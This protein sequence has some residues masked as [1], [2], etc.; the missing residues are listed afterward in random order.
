M[1][2]KWTTEKP[3]RAG[4]YWW[5]MGTRDAEIVEIEEIAGI[6]TVFQTGYDE[7]LAKSVKFWEGEWAGPLEEP[8]EQRAA[9]ADKDM[10]ITTCNL[11]L[12]ER[13]REIA[14][15]KALL[16]KQEEE[17]IVSLRSS[18]HSFDLQVRE[19]QADL[20]RVIGEAV[21]ATEM[22]QLER[23]SGWADTYD[24]EMSDE[25]VLG[26]L[27]GDSVYQRANAFL[28]GPLVTCWRTWQEGK[29]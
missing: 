6:L 13:D 23:A 26:Q 19:L 21:W 24:C 17:E 2:P 20:D 14:Q 29:G 18:C 28:R 16:A 1:K 7:N 15:L 4:W 25:Q 22:L 11:A 5:R 8:E 12:L 9:L 3:S 10:E 27:S